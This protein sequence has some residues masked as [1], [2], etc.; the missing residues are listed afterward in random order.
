MTG[1]AAIH[2]C[3][4]VLAHAPDLVRHG[5]K[6]T[7]E[8]AADS[9]GLLA[10]IS[11][12]LRSY[13]E[14]LGYPPNQVLVGNLR[15]E[16]L[17]EVERPW[18]QHP[19][20]A[21]SEGPYGVIVDQAELYR[22]MEESDSFG[23]F[24]LDGVAAGNGALTITDDGRGIGSMAGAHDVDESLSA[25][26]LLENLAC[27]ATGALALEHVLRAS[28]LAPESVQYV[29][30]SGEEA[31]GDRYQ[32]GGG[33]LGKA[34]AE[35]AGCVNASG[36]DVKAFCCAPVHAL[37]AAGSLV[38]AGVYPHVIVVAGGSLAK[39]GMK[40]SG[41]LRHGVPVLEDVLAGFAVVVGP[42]GEGA[43]EIR[44]DAVGRHRVGSG[45]AQQAV[46]E[47]L[48]VEPLERLGRRILDVDRYATELHDP[49][50]TEP[51]GAGNV[52]SRNY[53]LIGA[54]AVRRGELAR[55]DLDGF[56]RAH[57]LPGFSPTQ[58]HVA[59]AVPWLPHGLAA[60]RAGEIGST[61]LLAKGSLFLGRMTE[62]ADGLS[63]IL[64]PGKE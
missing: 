50:I 63:I 41:A 6:P 24:K 32:R 53:K 5:S 31:V 26:V 55:E 34:I 30:G 58:G 25:A 64:E 39:L 22:R 9:D 45:S 27:K 42:P 17:W 36:S 18:W 59:S 10:S 28:G 15:P 20:D 19:V 61:M 8:L 33:N 51:A 52:P 46:L 37:V 35:Q 44:L 49:E 3:S 1:R 14:A 38:A 60:L 4:M 47:D 57:G 62:L 40:F 48:V 43:P 21:R 11:G 12:A 54:L 29:I 2:A 56:E 13:D 23:L 16:A 7:R